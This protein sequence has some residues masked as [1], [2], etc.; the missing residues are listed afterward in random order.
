MKNEFL[1]IY[2]T[3]ANLVLKTLILYTMFSHLLSKEH[4]NSSSLSKT[5]NRMGCFHFRT[6][7]RKNSKK[8]LTKQKF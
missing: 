4:I 8:P 6:K 3:I 1:Y 2:P 7:K 5:Y